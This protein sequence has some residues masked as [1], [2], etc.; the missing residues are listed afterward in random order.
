MDKRFFFSVIIPVYNAEQY[1]RETLES[2]IRQTI[3]FEEH[4][5]MILVDDG[6]RDGSAAICREYQERWPQNIVM[7]CQ[8]NAGVSRARNHG[9]E[10][11]L[12][13]YVNFL[14]SDD[15][16]TEES[17]EHARSFLEAEKETIDVAAARICFFGAKM[18]YH[19]LDFKFEDGT[20]VVDLTDPDQMRMIQST[21]ATTFI[22]REAI[23]DLRFDT[24]LSLGED[25]LF[26]SKMILKKQAYG[27]LADAL[28]LYRRRFQEDSAV[29]RQRFN[30]AYYQEAIDRYH[31]ELKR[32]CMQT[33]GRVPLFIQ[34]LIVYDAGY[35]LGNEIYKEVLTP[36]EAQVYE[37]KMKEVFSGIEDAVIMKN[38]IHRSIYRKE[39]MFELA[40]GEAFFGSMHFDPEKG[41]LVYHETTAAAFRRDKYRYCLIDAA[42][43]TDGLLTLEGRVVSWV[44]RATAEGG[45]FILSAEGKEIEPLLEDYPNQK[46]RTWKGEVSRYKRFVLKLDLKE[47]M[48]KD[49]RLRIVPFLCYGNERIKLYLQTGALLPG[50]EKDFIGYRFYGPYSLRIYEKIIEI[51]KPSNVLVQKMKNETHLLQAAKEQGKTDLYQLRRTC[52]QQQ[53]LPGRK[54]YLILDPGK[55]AGE[56]A[57]VFFRFLCRKKPFGVLPVFVT[58]RIS[59]NTEELKR[60]GKVISYEDPAFQN[61]VLR[62]DKIVAA[63]ETD[64]IAPAFGELYEYVKDLFHFHIY[65]LHHGDTGKDLSEEI[66]RSERGWHRILTVSEASKRRFMDRS[67]GYAKEQ[68][69]VTG[70]ARFDA[71]EDRGRRQILLMPEGRTGPAG[72]AQND[73]GTGLFHFYNRLIHDQRLLEEMRAQH[74]TGILC[75]DKLQADQLDHLEENEVFLVNRQE[76]DYNRLLNESDLLVTDYS[77]VQYDFAYLGKPV[78]YAQIDKEEFF[79]DQGGAESGFLYETEGFG[80]VCLSYEDLLEHLIAAVRGR[81]RNPDRY[82]EREEKCL[83][84]R[85]RN[86]CERIF[87][88]IRES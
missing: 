11:A 57:E 83:A 49:P 18:E 45:R 71:L 6:S 29:N 58:D 7:V 17:F 3:G 5:Q 60:I 52:L 42:S 31:L 12:G 78:L 75:M 28:Y 26:I 51:Y 15:K 82:R 14:D 9:L 41:T 20:R 23:G 87:R 40:N 34:S 74:Y 84:F 10:Y 38:P 55:G 64:R 37:Q 70:A 66:N 61:L 24:G 22:R 88:Q 56:D 79:K 32:Y 62:A 68:I 39:Q 33:Y 80:P 8:E 72:L 63:E 69:F 35:R 86:N 73:S 2:V 53:Y 65:Y 46:A 16:W 21:A 81:C 25:G 43:V 13:E 54:V 50:N 48:K 85:D 27:L 19:G 77:R 30:K 47:P 1:L 67:Y 4:I 44:L 76:I 59:G 36:G